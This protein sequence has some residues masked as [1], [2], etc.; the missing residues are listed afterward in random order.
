MRDSAGRRL[1]F[2]L[3]FAL[4]AGALVHFYNPVDHVRA[5]LR[6]DT[7]GVKLSLEIAARAVEACVKRL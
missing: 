6:A 1:G 4:A 7:G 5:D 2:A 3:L